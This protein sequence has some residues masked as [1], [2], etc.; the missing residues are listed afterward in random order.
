YIFMIEKK[1]GGILIENQVQGSSISTAVAGIGLNVN[2]RHFSVPGATSLAL[3]SGIDHDLGAVFRRLLECIESQYL[4]L[5][6]G[7]VSLLKQRYLAAL[8]K[9]REQQDFEALGENFTGTIH[10]VDEDGKLC[11]ETAGAVRKFA[12]KEVTFLN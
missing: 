9:F 4:D 6:S 3:C 10:D 7:N 2:Q 12:F 1:T 8:F 11:V 5:K